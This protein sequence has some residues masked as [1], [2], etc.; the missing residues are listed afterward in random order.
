M[1]AGLPAGALLSLLVCGCAASRPGAGDDAQAMGEALADLRR[2]KQEMVVPRA[3]SDCQ[4]VCRLAELICEASERICA[5]ARR[6][7]SDQAYGE[8]CRGAEGDCRAARRDCEG[9]Q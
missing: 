4:A 7:G 8:R 3:G 1:R 2:A 9:C 5:I 6:H